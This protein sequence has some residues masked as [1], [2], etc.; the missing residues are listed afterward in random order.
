MRL[1]PTTL[2][3]LCLLGTFPTACC[4][5]ASPSTHSCQTPDETPAEPSALQVTQLGSGELNA[6]GQTW[7]YQLLKLEVPGRAPTYAQW[8][9]PRKPGVSP[10]VMLTKPYDGIA[11]TGEAV[12]A[13]WAARGAGIHPDDSEPHHGP[14]SSPIAFTPTTPEII[15]GEA[16]IYLFHDF[17][18]LAVFGRFYAGGDLQNDRDDMNAGMRFLAQAPNVDTKRI[19]VFGGSWGGY[20]ALYAAADAPSTV[21]PAVG[22]ALAP[23]SDFAAEVDYVSRVVPSRVSNPDLRTRYQQFF[24]PYFRRIHATTGGD[25]TTPGTDYTRW[26]AAHLASTVQTPFLIL[27]DDWDTLIPV[28]HTR[29]LVSQ[30]PRRFTPLYLQNLTTV[31]WNTLPPDHGPLLTAHGGPVITMSVGHLMVALG[32]ADQPL[33]VPHAQGTVRAWLQGVHAAQAQGRDVSDVVPRLLELTDPRVVMFEP[34]LGTLQPGAAFIA[35]EVNA[36]WG[37]GFTDVNVRS[38]LAPGLPTP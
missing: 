10:I 25:P 36:V 15:A 5:N 18:V 31:D 4:S 29:A 30:A 1:F 19:G 17:G 35:Q 11:W 9:P 32:A 7:P 26:T 3:A 21:V 34:S 23:L 13:K 16:F 28:E 22:V 14:G 24:E 8:F 12:D 37:T 27:H 20:E 6:A 38:V 33:Y 2:L